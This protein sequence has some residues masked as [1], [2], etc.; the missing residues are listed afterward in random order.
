MIFCCDMLKYSLKHKNILCCEKRSQSDLFNHYHYFETCKHVFLMCRI[1]SWTV[2][3][4]VKN[5][6]CNFFRDRNFETTRFKIY[7]H[8]SKWPEI[9]EHLK[10]PKHS[11]NN[12]KVSASFLTSELISVWRES[13]AAISCG[14]CFSQRCKRGLTT[15][16][17]RLRPSSASGSSQRR[18]SSLPPFSRLLR[19]VRV[20]HF[21]LF[22]PFSD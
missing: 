3:M 8:F 22:G 16:G 2:K 1:I 21:V 7:R 4:F 14:V 5:Q 18:L 9:P 15:D 20:G 10:F 17:C 6:S 19:Y 11:R 13:R 12:L